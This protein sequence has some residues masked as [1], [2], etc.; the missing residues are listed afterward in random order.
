MKKIILRFVLPGIALALVIAVAV[1]VCILT[2]RL[3]KQVTA[4]VVRFYSSAQ[5]LGE[6][7]VKQYAAELEQGGEKRAAFLAEKKAQYGL[8]EAQVKEI[9]AH[10]DEYDIYSVTVTVSHEMLFILKNVKI[11]TR[12]QAETWMFT[13][14]D[15]SDSGKNNAADKEETRVDI[16]QFS[17][18]SY[19]YSILVKTKDKNEKQIQESIAACF[20]KATFHYE[21][22]DLF[23]EYSSNEKLFYQLF[24]FGSVKIRQPEV[25]ENTQEESETETEDGTTTTAAGSSAAA[26][27]T[28]P[29]TTATQSS[30]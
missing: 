5:L 7:P 21:P 16:R 13:Q 4:E 26:D 17:P 19:T 11:K 15:I 20:Q 10:P 18:K 2:G 9:A 22:D 24:G 23:W 25:T 3:N 28:S 27:S 6:S 29:D 12:K 30:E 1:T 14:G 8:S